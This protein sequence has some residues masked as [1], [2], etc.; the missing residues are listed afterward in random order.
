MFELAP[1]NAD[2]EPGQGRRAKIVKLIDKL[3]GGI[4]PR[5]TQDLAPRHHPKSRQ[6]KPTWRKKEAE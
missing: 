4:L 6:R 5:P 3:P 2:A 1:K